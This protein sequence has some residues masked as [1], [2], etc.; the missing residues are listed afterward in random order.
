M[1]S[2]PLQYNITLSVYKSFIITDILF[3]AE[4]NSI[5]WSSWYLSIYF[6]PNLTFIIL[7]SS[8]PYWINNINVK[9]DILKYIYSWYT[10]NSTPHNLAKLIRDSS[11]GDSAL[12]INF[13][14]FSSA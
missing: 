9:L 13:P 4:L 8:V 5:L 3:L 14:S 7:F 11:S 2:A 1:L 12:Y 6:S 10:S